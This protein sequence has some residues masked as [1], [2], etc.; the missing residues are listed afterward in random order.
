MIFSCASDS[1][2]KP[3]RLPGTCSRYSK[4]AIPHET[5]AAIHQ[6]FDCRCFRWPY[7]AKVM[8]RFDTVRNAAHTSAGWIWT[9]ANEGMYG[10]LR[11]EAAQRG[12][13]VATGIVSGASPRY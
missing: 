6:G 8:N 10:G 4:S 11:S 5:S 12:R 7:H 13:G 1:V 9:W 2:V 3:I